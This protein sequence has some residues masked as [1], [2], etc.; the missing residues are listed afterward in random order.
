VNGLRLGFL[1]F[2]QRYDLYAAERLYATRSRPGPQRLQLS[3]ARTDLARLDGGVDLKIA[4]V[5]WGRNYRK[6]NPRQERL[7]AALRSAG[8]ELIVGH[9]PHIPHPVTIEEGAPV[10]YSLGNG[11]LG[12]PGRFH[13]GRP[14][15]G[16]VA[17]VD[18]DAAARPRRLTMELIHVDNAHVNFQPVVADG[19]HERRLLR[20]L[21][22][23]NLPW[24][25]RPDEG[26][27]ADLPGAARASAGSG[28]L[29]APTDG[30]GQAQ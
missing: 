22:P 1:S 2:M 26:F 30:E 20:K 10:F 15:Y 16:L 28:H 18:L 3:R 14:P 13:S 29:W 19:A 25:E 9:H 17:S 21:L 11:P 7:A 27:V 12:T 8:A 5:H 23:W 4:L 24:E 6:C